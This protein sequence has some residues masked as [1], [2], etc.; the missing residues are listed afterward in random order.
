LRTK[1][2]LRI[3][4]SALNENAGSINFGWETRKSVFSRLDGV[5]SLDFTKFDFDK[6]SFEFPFAKTYERRVFE[7]NFNRIMF[8]FSSEE[9]S[10][11]AINEI[12][13]LYTVTGYIKGVR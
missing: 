9:N 13:A 6:L 2:L 3:G 4:V 10:D 11:C 1:T 12:N 8:K 5:D 7:R